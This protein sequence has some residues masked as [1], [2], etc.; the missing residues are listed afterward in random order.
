MLLTPLPASPWSAGAPPAPSTPALTENVSTDVAI[1]GGG[2][3]G[4]SA[5]LTLAQKGVSV[6][7][8]DAQE[9]G[10]GG[11]GRNGGQVIPSWKHD[12]NDLLRLF[13]QEQGQQLID[14]FS[15]TVEEVFQLIEQH[16]LAC[17]ARRS[18][19]IQAAHDEVAVRT[20]Q[21]R[22]AQWQA[23]GVAAQVLDR[24]GMAQWL[25][26]DFYPGGWLDPRAAN[27]NP[28]AFARGLARVALKAGAQLHGNTRVTRLEPLG[29]R[30]R[31]HLSTGATLNA[32][33]VLLATN[34]YT[35]DLWPQLRQTLIAANSFQIATPPL[36][37]EQRKHVLPGG[38]SVSD[39]RRVLR[40]FR[41]DA[42]GRLIMGGRGPFREPVGPEDFAHLDRSVYQMFP[43]LQGIP[44]EFR[45][46]G[47]VG[48]TRDFM[49]HIH[50]P[51]PG[52]L[53]C[54]GYNGRGVG[55]A[56]SMGRRLAQHLLDPQ[57]SPLP[58]PFTQLQPIPLHG[59]HTIYVSVL[60]AW[61]RFLDALGVG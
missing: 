36:T 55:L 52:L 25:G 37:Q 32:E 46:A 41:V 4:L 43:V 33:Q 61:Y 50:R 51:A 29:T 1:V 58:L 13:G 16:Q 2:Y 6:R 28:L 8:L 19:W 20:I 30:W 53:A 35:D 48:L 3:T 42:A 45:W 21:R 15:G 57:G 54:V 10:A 39:T 24:Q 34:A 18:G 17:D 31:L 56:T 27:L 9:P 22:A 49:P 5:G 40:Y 47:R 60:I 44:F 14:L 12:P 38:A 7:V 26:T 59:L 11:S 23:R